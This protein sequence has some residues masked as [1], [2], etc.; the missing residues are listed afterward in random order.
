M[1]NIIKSKN[2]KVK[3]IARD[4]KKEDIKNIIILTSYLIILA[5]IGFAIQIV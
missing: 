4:R 3:V 5:I 2:N 1:K